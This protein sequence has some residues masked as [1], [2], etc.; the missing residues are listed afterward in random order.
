MAESGQKTSGTHDSKTH[1][2]GTVIGSIVDWCL[3]SAL[4]GL[5]SCEVALIGITS[6]P[7]APWRPRTARELTVYAQ[8]TVS[9]VRAVHNYFEGMAIR[10]RGWRGLGFG[11]R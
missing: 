7:T 10:N 1:D 8:N 5:A 2:P 4:C 9:G 3:G 6:G 11:R